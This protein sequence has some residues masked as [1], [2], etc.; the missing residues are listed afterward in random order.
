M[1]RFY[2]PVQ[3]SHAPAHELHNGGFAPYAEVPARAE[4]IRAA[5]GTTEVPAD[6]G[7]A[8][9]AAVHDPAYLAFLRDAP[10]LWAE[11]GRPGD[12]IPYAFPIVG[13]RPLALSRIDALLG[14]HSFDATT[15]ITPQACVAASADCALP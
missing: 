4:A 8:P 12:A 2:A 14:A 1:R 11:A 6:R 3:A 15:P 9:I 10:R 7:E 5:I 13:R